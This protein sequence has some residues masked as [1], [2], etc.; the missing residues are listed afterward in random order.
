[1][2]HLPAWLS[3][4]LI[5]L[6][7]AVIA[8]PL[9]RALG[10]G[11]IIGYIAAGIAIGP[12]GIGL[13]TEVED[14]LHFAEF[15]VVLML[16][17]VGL[18]LEP[19][20][21]WNLRRPIF[22]WG[23]AQVVGCAVVLFGAGVLA[24]ADWR[25]SL[26]AAL[27]LALSSTAIALQVMGERN[28]LPTSSGQANFSILLFQD[29]AA[30]PIL[31]L[32][33][34]LAG[35]QPDDGAGDGVLLQ[36]LKIVAVIAAIVLGGRLALRPLL[37]WIAR[38]RTPEIFTAAAL[39]LVVAIA[40]L[41]QIVGLSMALGAF[42]AGVLLAESEY[43]RELET[44][45]EPFKGLLLGLF[46]IAVGMSIDFGALLAQPLLMA[47]LV[48]GFLLLKAA[49]IWFL[50]KAM[51][52][53]RQDRPVFTL[54][55]A[56]GGEFAFVVFQ[57]AAGAHVFPAATA[58]LLIGA[59]AVSMLLSPLLLVAIDRFVAARFTRGGGRTLEEISAE[60]DAP[61]IIAGF[62][63]YGQIVGRLMLAQGV[64][65][66]VLD[67]DADMVEVV[68][69]F[70]YKVFY[71]D[72]SRLDLLRIAGADKARV[73]VVAVDSA[74]QSLA[75]VDLARE[76]FPHLQ[77]VARARD[78]THWNELRDRQVMHVERELFEASL[79]SGRTVLELL[80]Q[81]PHEA[82]RLAM[83][84]RRHNIELFEQM[85]PNR[86]DRSKIIAVVKQGRRQLEEQLAR[87]REEVAARRHVGDDRPPGWDR[88][89][90][91]A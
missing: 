28:L 71:G 2:E 3:S 54:L 88:D 53:E 86:K 32:V 76:H 43:R 47:G 18:E 13:V 35:V 69:S 11:S 39:L 40:A 78:V 90:P 21:L 68:R 4:S 26:V 29:V 20:R 8:V 57:A 38:S 34:L 33:P 83:R 67:H 44:D 6:G 17:L 74:D 85:Y 51:G 7:A 16:F 48:A 91:G 77:L 12:W 63:R 52:I 1:M 66:T 82:R 41:M 89:R 80:G 56:Q 27:G 23:G 58:S 65:A 19:R 36:G 24:G 42:L 75:I 81:S 10:L 15:G 62:G 64:R 73:L 45:I 79:R 30:I 22:G 46:F 49:V 59:V 31:A 60:Q 9:S 84:F 5:Y 70:G 50:A 72:A 87:E 61:V 25:I 37:R 55:L 14:I